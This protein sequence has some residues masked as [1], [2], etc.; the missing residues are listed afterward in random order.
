MAVKVI[1][2]KVGVF[3][4]NN[5]IAEEVRSVNQ[6][7]GTFMV[8]IMASPGAG[9]TTTLLRTIEALKEDYRIGVLEADIEASVD[10]EKMAAAGVR[11]IQ[12]HT[13]G[14]CAMDASM[15]RQSLQQFDAKDLDVLFMENVGNLVCTA[16]Q[17]TGAHVNVEILSLPEG[18][19]KPLKYPLMF[20][21]C[22]CVLINKIDTREWFSFDDDAVRDR[23]LKLNP[24]AKIFF[25][26]AKTGEGFDAWIRWLQ[27]QAW[28][29]GVDAPGEWKGRTNTDAEDA[30]APQGAPKSFRRSGED[31]P[32]ESPGHCCKERILV[33]NPGSTSTK[34]A[35]FEGEREVFCET[36]RHPAED[37]EKYEK[38]AD[39][40]DFRRQLV[41]DA[42]REHGLAP[43]D[44]DAI[45]CRGGLTHPIPSGT[46]RIND[47][48]LQ[49][50]R[51]G[52][53]GEHA[54]N[55]G[56][57]IGHE[58]EMAA[59]IPAFVV[60]PP[61][62]DELSEKARFSGHPIIHRSSLFHALNQKAVARHYAAETGRRYEDLRLVVCHMGGGISVGAHCLGNVI[63]TENAVGGEGP[64]TPE[65]AGTMP[66]NE[67]VN[68]C[69][70][71]SYSQAEIMHMMVGEG[72]LYAYTGTTSIQELTKRASEGDAD[73]RL[74]LDAFCYQI[75][76]EIAAMSAAMRGRVDQI[77]L[78]GGIAHS[79]PL[80]VQLREAVEWI[81]PVT[82]Y[83]GEDEMLAL[84]QGAL[85]VLRGEES[86]KRYRK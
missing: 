5:R 41:L 53:Y 12:V 43:G 70:S 7:N 25:V 40:W 18:D 32:A 64:F 69:F 85:R 6:A 17:D 21:V 62:V 35:V 72:G 39:Q 44:M 78:T 68:L 11:S 10:A 29:H 45:S 54:S 38:I 48:L 60:D 77:I 34:I 15:V 49:D 71:G 36:L 83:P 51:S 2:V 81:A 3:D 33:I 86:A 22:Q 58:M 80:M 56:A 14:E 75:S 1:D 27:E 13:G 84:A 67:I 4:E 59:H 73:I 19:D 24:Q 82:V 30:D 52:A 65:R 42:L 76:K 66:V 20:T 57:L 79:E 28:E 55:L 47:A 63:D 37:L 9:K 50:C 16:E 61:S 23:I 31:A 74:L 26:S 46:Y 8:N